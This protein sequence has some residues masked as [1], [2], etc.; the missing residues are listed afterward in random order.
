[1]LRSILICDGKQIEKLEDKQVIAKNLERLINEKPLI[2]YDASRTHLD[3]MDEM[4]S[5]HL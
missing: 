5:E 1:M 4:S 2:Y 3:D